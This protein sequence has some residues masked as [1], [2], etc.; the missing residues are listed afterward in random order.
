MKLKKEYYMLGKSKDRRNLHPY[1]F[2]AEESSAG[3][4]KSRKI[5]VGRNLH[6]YTQ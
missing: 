4:V 3:L 6:P 1:T 2:E 5:K